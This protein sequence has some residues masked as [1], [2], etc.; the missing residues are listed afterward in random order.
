MT[1]STPK[2]VLGRIL[3]SY[4]PFFVRTVVVE[5]IT[6]LP[7]Y[8]LSRPVITIPFRGEEFQITSTYD[9]RT[10]L[11]WILYALQ[12]WLADSLRNIR[13][14]E[15]HLALL[16]QPEELARVEADLAAEWEARQ[17]QE[18]EGRCPSGGG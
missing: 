17:E 10:D 9:E 16:Q 15:K 2:P 13:S 4:P 7:H 5:D 12:L 14:W 6:D 8:V 1:N 11:P 3:R 18:A